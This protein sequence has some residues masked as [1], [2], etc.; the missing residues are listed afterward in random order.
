MTCGK[1]HCDNAPTEATKVD[2]AEVEGRPM[3]NCPGC[4]KR[5]VGD[6]RYCA[7]GHAQETMPVPSE[8]M[9]PALEGL[10]GAVA[11]L[12]GADPRWATDPRVL[13][14]REFAET[15]ADQHYQNCYAMGMAV[16]RFAT[17]IFNDV[18][19]PGWAEDARIQAARE[20][21]EAQTPADTAPIMREWQVLSGSRT[22]L[23]HTVVLRADGSYGCTC[24]DHRY[25]EHDCYHIRDVQRGKWGNGTL[26]AGATEEP[27]AVPEGAAGEPVEA[28]DVPSD[29]RGDVT[30]YVMRYGDGSLHCSCEDFTYRREGQPDKEA[31]GCK[32]TRGVEDGAYGE[33]HPFFANAYRDGDSNRWL[34]PSAGDS[35]EQVTV[36]AAGPKKCTCRYW[37]EV[38]QFEGHECWHMAATRRALAEAEA[39]EPQRQWLYSWTV[40]SRSRAE[41]THTVSL[42]ADGTYKCTCEDYQYRVSGRYGPKSKDECDHMRRV[43][44]GQLGAGHPIPVEEWEIPAKAHA[45]HHVVTLLA[46]GTYLCNCEWS[47]WPS[48]RAQKDCWHIREAKERAW[49]TVREGTFPRPQ[50]RV[51]GRVREVKVGARD[52][53]GRAREIALPQCPTTDQ[54][55]MATM[56]Y[57]LLQA[58]VPWGMIRQQ[59]KLPDTVRRDEVVS[60]VRSVGR[61]VRRGQ[62]FAVVPPAEHDGLRLTAAPSS[63]PVASPRVQQALA[64]GRETLVAALRDTYI[65]DSD[66][67]EGGP[68]DITNRGDAEL[69]A[70]G[71]AYKYAG[72]YNVQAPDEVE[73]IRDELVRVAQ[74]HYAHAV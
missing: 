11:D 72:W 50:F 48:R 20:A 15:S 8:G 43:R 66:V 27:P 68:V 2:P 44:T 32:H 56:C 55:F 61:K 73:A 59:L 65:A 4:D 71:L 38:G 37:R 57:D 19:D 6:G 5:V 34:V 45:G 36:D 64:K 52:T 26:V 18:D 9:P 28:W 46:D 13:A 67:A 25:R 69:V 29:S 1:K 63:R 42:A 54:H 31:E 7:D 35:L 53:R 70:E 17:T 21:L 22:D 3:C 58:G 47:R 14:L 60:Y 30:H 62:G 16:M 74:E 33:G 24:E 41:Q 12:L 40:P 23:E 51:D 49:P 10:S 39:A